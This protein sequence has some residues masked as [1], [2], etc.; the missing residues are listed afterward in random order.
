MKINVTYLLIIVFAV[1]SCGGTT[2]QSKYPYQDARLPVEERVHDLLGRMTVDEKI[3]QL[4][5]YWGKEVAD[6]GGHEAASYS[7]EK[8]EE[9]IGK[10]GIGSIHDFYPIR[11]KLEM[12]YKSM[13]WRKPVFGIPVLFIEEGLH[14]YCGLGS[15]SFPVP[16]ELASAWDTALIHTIGRA[17]AA[18]TRALGVDMI[19]RRLTGTRGSISSREESGVKYLPRSIQRS[20]YGKRIPGNFT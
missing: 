1:F 13:L 5:M 19:W 10:T 15:T 17:I 6:M 2:K 14:G 7:E 4:D 8:V 12:K 9:V 18:E 11:A 3:Q 16:L 20:C